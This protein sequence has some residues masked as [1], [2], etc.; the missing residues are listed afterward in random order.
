MLSLEQRTVCLNMHSNVTSFEISAI[1]HLQIIF[2]HAQN[3]LFAMHSGTK[4]LARGE[5]NKT[6]KRHCILHIYALIP[7]LNFCTV[8]HLDNLDVTLTGLR[9]FVI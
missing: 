8:H 3:V 7:E 2:A 5:I 1:D 9:H 6:N 4:R